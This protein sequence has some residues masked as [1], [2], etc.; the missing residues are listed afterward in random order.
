MPMTFRRGWIAALVAGF[1]VSCGAAVGPADEVEGTYAGLLSV[2]GED[3][4][5]GFQ[6]RLNALDGN[7]LLWNNFDAVVN[8]GCPAVRLS[9]GRS[10]QTYT[11][12]TTTREPCRLDGQV[13]GSITAISGTLD[14]VGLTLSIGVVVGD[15]NAGSTQQK[16]ATFTAPPL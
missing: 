9:V 15:V 11:L 12:G 2:I 10:G 1:S 7:T 16:L 14:G 6:V 8:L 5:P 3:Q 4:R 13:S